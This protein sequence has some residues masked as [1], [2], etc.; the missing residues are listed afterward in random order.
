MGSLDH[1]LIVETFQEIASFLQYLPSLQ[2][3][4]PFYL[5]KMGMEIEYKWQLL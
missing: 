2:V 4:I 1:I 5:V 3:V